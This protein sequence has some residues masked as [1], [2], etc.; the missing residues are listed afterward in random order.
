VC[1][2]VCVVMEEDMIL[3]RKDVLPKKEVSK[4]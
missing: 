2:C 1:V 3:D 4:S